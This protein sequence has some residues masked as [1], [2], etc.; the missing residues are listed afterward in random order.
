MQAGVEDRDALSRVLCLPPRS[1]GCQAGS[2]C[3]CRWYGSWD[4]RS[5]QMNL[6]LAIQCLLGVSFIL[7]ALL[8][9]LVVVRK[10][11]RDRREAT[12]AK[13]R[14]LLQR[15]A[16]EGTVVELAEALRPAVP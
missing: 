9:V 14:V 6:L 11:G 3:R 16:R 13:R 5:R 1:G 15:L 12:S 10:Y 4:P 8:T 7:W 2:S